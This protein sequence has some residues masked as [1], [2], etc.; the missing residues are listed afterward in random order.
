M[1]SNLKKLGALALL[2]AAGA[3][4]AAVDVSAITTGITDSATAV[5]TIGA[6][7]LLVVLGIKTFKWLQR[8]L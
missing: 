6:A 4:Q 8:S 3:S 1:N 5:G 7:V 2:G